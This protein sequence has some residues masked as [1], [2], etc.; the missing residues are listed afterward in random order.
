MVWVL[1]TVLIGLVG[2]LL[3]LPGR[4]FAQPDPAEVVRVLSREDVY[5]EPVMAGR[6]SAA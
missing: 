6:L 3:L 5:I 4:A 2:L 1:R